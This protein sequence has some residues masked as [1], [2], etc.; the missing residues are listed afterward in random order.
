MLEL[1][2]LAPAP[3]EAG[4]AAPAMQTVGAARY[5][6]G[7]FKLYEAELRSR[8]GAF[9]WQEPFDLTL[10]YTRGF[11][12]RKLADVSVKEMAR[13]TGRKE[14]LLAPL[15]AKLTACFADVRKGD[16][17]VGRSLSMNEAE[18]TYNG[19]P[20]CRIAWT[21]FR[22]D[23]FGIWLSDKARFEEQAARLKGERE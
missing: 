5:Q 6:L 23:F 9:S 3:L 13:M 21:D 7:P 22:S 18:F 19:E 20:R 1:V 10:T 12:A 4:T 8:N 2:L 14:S 17:I 11:S 16:V 15:R